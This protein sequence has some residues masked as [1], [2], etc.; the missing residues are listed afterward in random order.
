M[1]SISDSLSLE[2]QKLEKKE[3]T[4][5]L[6]VVIFV[7]GWISFDLQETLHDFQQEPILNPFLS[8]SIVGKPE[9]HFR[10]LSG[11]GF[12]MISAEAL[13][14]C[15]I[16]IKLITKHGLHMVLYMKTMG[17]KFIHLLLLLLLLLFG[18]FPKPKQS[19]T[20]AILGALP[21]CKKRVTTEVASL[22]SVSPLPRPPPPQQRHKPL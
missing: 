8:I 19:T 16:G 3:L 6:K 13:M 5:T 21:A 11:F 9:K 17:L 15:Q 20:A 18:G 12:W 14:H 1:F 22:L 10:V 2:M 7:T 4:S